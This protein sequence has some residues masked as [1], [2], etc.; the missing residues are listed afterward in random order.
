VA[1]SPRQNLDGAWGFLT[2]LS[3]IHLANV[4]LGEEGGKA[5]G[6][7]F[8]PRRSGT[9]VTGELKWTFPSN[10]RVLNLSKTGLGVGGA[11]H[12]ADAL[13]PRRD[14]ETGRWAH[15]PRLKELHLGGASIGPEGAKAIADAIKPRRDGS[16][17]IPGFD[18]DDA[19]EDFAITDCAYSNEHARSVPQWRFNTSLQVLDLRDN[20]LCAE[21]VSCIADA[22]APRRD[23]DPVGT[24]DADDAACFAMDGSSPVPFATPTSNH[25]NVNKQSATSSPISPKNWVYGGA[26]AVLNLEF[27]DAGSAGIAALAAALAPRWCVGSKTTKDRFGAA[28]ACATAGDSTRGGGNF[29]CNFG[30]NGMI[31]GGGGN[32]NLTSLPGSPRNSSARNSRPSSARVG[33]GVLATSSPNFANSPNASQE[34]SPANTPRGALSGL[35]NLRFGN[36][37][38]VSMP[39]TPSPSAASARVSAQHERDGGRPTSARSPSPLAASGGAFAAK[40][41]A[42]EGSGSPRH[43]PFASSSDFGDGL[44]TSPSGVCGVGGGFVGS[45]LDSHD[46]D[47]ARREPTAHWSANETLRA[48]GIDGNRAGDEGAAALANAIAPVINPDGT[49]TSLRLT[50]LDASEN[51]IGEHGLLAL[52]RAIDPRCSN[53]RCACGGGIS[54]G[55]RSLVKVS[56]PAGNSPASTVGSRPSSARGLRGF[57]GGELK[58]DKAD[59]MRSFILSQ[60]AKDAAL[61]AGAATRAATAFDTTSAMT[62][63][64][65][66]LSPSGG[67][68]PLPTR[69]LVTDRR[70]GETKCPHDDTDQMQ[71]TWSFDTAYATGSA[72]SSHR[73]SPDESPVENVPCAFDVFTGLRKLDLARNNGSGEKIRHALVELKEKLRTGAPGCDVSI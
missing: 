24:D 29:M 68:F 17:G 8:R 49:W 40:S 6:D 7:V 62:T 54:V 46:E 9:G 3:T 57:V 22:V 64:F 28:A 59:C 73:G 30:R 23:D 70:L 34:N 48:L 47:E 16:A 26:L 11:K 50:R 37:G 10:L 38:D 52:A 32:S 14:P 55:G 27:N 69:G 65:A 71:R 39:H 31:G 36:A 66:S 35:G 19:L 51:D 56:T 42:N 18:D 2:T 4:L 61:A 58:K 45:G 72:G 5:L 41:F 33:R 13:R 43:L 44:G 67:D 12:I 63:G 21:G 20:V 25:P 15:N 1:L 53:P 60:N